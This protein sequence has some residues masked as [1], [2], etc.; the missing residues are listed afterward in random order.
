MTSRTGAIK[1]GYRSPIA[2]GYH[3]AR[4]RG[5]SSRWQRERETA[6]GRR[7]E[8][9]FR[10][11]DPPRRDLWPTFPSVTPPKVVENRK[12][13]LFIPLSRPPLSFSFLLS[14]SSPT[15]AGNED[16]ILIRPRNLRREIAKARHK[17]EEEAGQA[18]ARERRSYLLVPV[19]S[20]ETHERT[21]GLTMTRNAPRMH[22]MVCRVVD[23][24]ISLF[25]PLSFPLA[26]RMR[27]RTARREKCADS[28]SRTR[29]WLAIA[30]FD[31]TA[32]VCGTNVG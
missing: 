16:G 20:A 11:K 7:A 30:N 28:S 10:L 21:D 19:M 27:R 24:S 17:E 12:A 1:S 18:P 31:G 15:F 2:V 9:P 6:R 4:F 22:R 14:H 25:L 8:E 5:R 26:A 23:P 13:L 29:E 32:R 3:G